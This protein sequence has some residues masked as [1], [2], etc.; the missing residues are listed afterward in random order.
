MHYDI[1]IVGAGPAGAQCARY[2]S[3]HSKYSVL[4]LDKTQEIGEPKKSTAGTFPETMQVF[5]LPRS[6][7]QNKTHAIIF[8]GPTE[9]TELPM[10]GYVLDF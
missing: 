4:L 5:D 7:V 2:I 9:A 1:I 8:E 6:V 3:E 10:E